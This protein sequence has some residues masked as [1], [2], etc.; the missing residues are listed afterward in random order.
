MAGSVR[1]PTRSA[2]CCR[3]EGSSRKYFGVPQPHSRGVP[4][5]KRGGAGQGPIYRELRIVPRD[6]ALVLGGVEIRGLVEHLG[7]VAQ[8]AEPMSETDGNPEH[9]LRLGAQARAFPL[10]ERRRSATDIDRDVENLARGD[11]NQFPL[12]LT[13]LI[14][15]TAQDA[16][17]GARM[18]VLHELHPDSGALEFLL[19]PAFEEEAAG[20]AEHLRLEE[21]EPG[22]SG[23]RDFHAL[24]RPPLSLSSESK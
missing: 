19:V 9:A 4:A 3:S 2:R 20:V 24:R 10:A 8:H 13:H 6:A 12:R 23:R 21:K 18:V 7:G 5:R 17:F 1:A 16:L 15:K 22:E 11:A 14:V